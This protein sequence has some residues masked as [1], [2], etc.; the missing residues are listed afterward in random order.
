[1]P[2]FLRLTLSICKEHSMET[3]DSTTVPDFAGMAETGHPSD[4][5]E[6]LATLPRA[7]VLSLLRGLDGETAASLFSY[8][9]EELQ[10]GLFHDMNKEKAARLL[11]HLPADERADLYGLLDAQ[12][13]RNILPSLEQGIREDMLHLASFPEE[14]TGS[15][16]TSEYISVLP[17]TRVAAALK[18]V[19][20][21]QMQHFFHPLFY[22]IACST[23]QLKP[24]A[25]IFRN[26]HMRKQRII[27]KHR[28]HIAAAR[29]FRGNVLSAKPHFPLVG[30]FKTGDNA[31]RRRFSAA[32]S[33]QQRNKFPLRYIE[34]YSLQHRHGAKPLMQIF[35]LQ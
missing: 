11:K 16:T 30:V 14:S 28:I 15:A 2:R 23:P 18:T 3:P 9:S 21:H 33:A 4:L 31:Q 35:Q 17:E 29:V 1:M 5:A 7:S 34:T 6:E 12:A 20:L 27:L 19:K 10:T 24:V 32:G 13:R 25:D 22:F 8:F 26:S